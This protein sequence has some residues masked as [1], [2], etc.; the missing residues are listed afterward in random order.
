[1]LNGIAI[2]DVHLCDKSPVCRKDDVRATQ[3]GK[4]RQVAALCKK[5]RCPLFIAGDLY[6]RWDVSFGLINQ[7]NREF[8]NL[9]VHAVAGNHDLPY[10][11]MKYYDEGP[12]SLTYLERPASKNKP[13]LGCNWGAEPAGEPKEMCLIHKM[14]YLSEPVKGFTGNAHDV[15]HLMDTPAYRNIQLVIS[16]DNHKAFVYEHR[17]G[18]VWLNTG[19]IVRTDVTEKHYEPSAWYFEVDN[20]RVTVERHKL[21]V[22]VEA[23][24]RIEMYV[25]QFKTS[26]VSQFA[27]EIGKQASLSYDYMDSVKSLLTTEE[28]EQEIIDAVMGAVEEAQKETK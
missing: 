9:E 15:K 19:P 2:G 11:S 8:L 10:H 1:M 28:L 18:R 12:M 5:Y 7:V 26:I 27:D 16:G 4:L 20:G 23:V 21:D 13:W 25:E 14:V 6:D 24:D 17:D 3:L 22:D